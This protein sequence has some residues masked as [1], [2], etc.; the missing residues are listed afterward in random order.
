MSQDVF[1]KVLRRAKTLVTP[2]EPISSDS[3]KPILKFLEYAG[4]IQNSQDADRIFMDIYFH[5]ILPTQPTMKITRCA[6]N[7]M[8][9]SDL[10]G[11]SIIAEKLS[12]LWGEKND[13]AALPKQ[14]VSQLAG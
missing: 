4:N 7:S 6:W 11:Y 8:K 2:E 12:A 3:L 14:I 10:E 13:T 9:K 1:Q 5:F